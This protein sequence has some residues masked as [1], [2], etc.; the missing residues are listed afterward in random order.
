MILEL[1][2]KVCMEYSTWTKGR[3]QR[4]EGMFKIQ[5]APCGR[6]TE[7]TKNTLEISRK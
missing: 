6:Y 5:K 7:K 4:W 3:L 2:F 1:S